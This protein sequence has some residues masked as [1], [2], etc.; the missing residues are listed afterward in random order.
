MV[1]IVAA[2]IVALGPEAFDV[3]ALRPALEGQRAGFN[4]LDQVIAVDERF[5]RF[6]D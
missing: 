3:R 4:A 1:R 6:T 2:D 5:V